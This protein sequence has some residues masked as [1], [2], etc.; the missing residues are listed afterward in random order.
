MGKNPTA[1]ILLDEIDS[2]RELPNQPERTAERL[3]GIIDLAKKE[4]PR[5]IFKATTNYKDKIP[6]PLLSRFKQNILTIENPTENQR[7]DIILYHIRRL[8]NTGLQ[9]RLDTT[10]L[11]TLI[12]N[13]KYFS[14]RD[15]ESL[16]ENIIG[17]AHLEAGER[18]IQQTAPDVAA[19]SEAATSLS[20]SIVTSNT[21]ELAYK[22]VL[23]ELI[24]PDSRIERFGTAALE[25]A[26]KLAPLTTHG[27]LVLSGIGTALSFYSTYKAAR[28]RTEDIAREGQIIRAANERQDRLIRDANERQDK[29]RKEDQDLSLALHRDS[30]KQS[31]HQFNLSHEIN[32]IQLQ[33]SQQAA[34]QRNAEAMRQSLS[35]IVEPVAH[36][37]KD[38]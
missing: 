22:T 21:V 6:D 25:L 28:N 29:Q 13:T 2:I 8:E 32:K 18:V 1:V 36:W 12:A 14:I 9:F 19:S 11:Q 20:R 7:G 31:E 37:L 33:L 35:G 10:Y 38:K 24:T 34:R 26:I 27:S 5:V 4:Y 17:R 15:L 16:F 23:A 3:Q 30:K